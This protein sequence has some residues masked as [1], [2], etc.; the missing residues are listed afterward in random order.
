MSFCD[1]FPDSPNCLNQLEI[2]D[3]NDP[4]A[5]LPIPEVKPIVVDSKDEPVVEPKME[6][7]EREEMEAGNPM[8]MMGNLV[9]LGVP[10]IHIVGISLDLFRYK[11]ASDYYD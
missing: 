2:I 1:L 5:P 6:V 9:F 3:P 8:F 10:A 4:F 7:E 11:S